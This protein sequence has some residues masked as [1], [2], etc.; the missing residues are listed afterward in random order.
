MSSSNATLSCGLGWGHPDLGRP[1]EGN[2]VPTA[3]IHPGFG[4]PD[5]LW[6][7][8]TRQRSAAPCTTRCMIMMRGLSMTRAALLV[9]TTFL[10]L[11][12]SSPVC[13]AFVHPPA[14]A[15]KPAHLAKARPPSLS[16]ISQR[17]VAP[18]APAGTTLRALPLIAADVGA[19][20]FQSMPSVVTS[21]AL[22]NAIQGFLNGPTV[23]LIPIGAAIILATC[24]GLL[25]YAI[26]QPSERD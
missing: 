19:G 6:W 7:A 20:S 23:L 17:V 15:S 2:K 1:G 12:F 5:L 11:F 3:P 22:G 21:T 24:V 9:V 13:R 10:I 14:A 25:I 16:S 8:T 4:E 18:G 26:S